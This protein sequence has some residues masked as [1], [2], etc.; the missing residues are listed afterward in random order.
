MHAWMDVRGRQCENNREY[1][2]DVRGLQVRGEWAAHEEWGISGYLYEPNWVCYDGGRDV[3]DA[4]VKT[5]SYTYC[6]LLM[7]P[8]WRPWKKCTADRMVLASWDKKLNRIALVGE[9]PIGQLKAAKI[10]THTRGKPLND[11]CHLIPWYDLIRPV[12]K[13]MTHVYDQVSLL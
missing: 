8:E 3:L 6:P 7:W 1:G 12:R 13:E 10:Y 9:C 5:V 4:D 2:P 11:P